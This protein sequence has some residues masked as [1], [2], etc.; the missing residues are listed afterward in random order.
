I[1]LIRKF[2]LNDLIEGWASLIIVTG[3]GTGLIMLGLGI[4][5]EYIHRINLKST[6]RPN[7]IERKNI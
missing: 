2:F 7:Y 4:T 6:K 5:G 3:F 1:T